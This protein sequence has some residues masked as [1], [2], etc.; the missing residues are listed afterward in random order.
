VPSPPSAARRLTR[1]QV[2]SVLLAL[3]IGYAS[4]LSA[5]VAW[6]ASLSSIDA[7][8]Y[9]SLAVQQQARREQLDRQLEGIVGQDLRLVDV[10]RE[11]ALA[12]R[13]LQAQADEVRADNTD[14]ADE[15]DLEA[16]GRLALARAVQPFLLGQ[17]GVYLNDDGTAA[18]DEARILRLLREGELELRELRPQETLAL[19]DE[20]SRHTLTLV[21]LAA[22]LIAALL[23]L[24]V[25]QVARRRQNARL[26]F[27]VAGAALVVVGTFALI[28]LELPFA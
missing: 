12:A 13:E 6:R 24:T 4:I 2:F 15:L 19:A 8:R 17:A 28:V 18:Y 3:L 7:A 16:Q 25:A 11:H 22:V 27:M 9:E 21:A 1:A 23:F 5:V 10:F 14:L 26:G 20:A